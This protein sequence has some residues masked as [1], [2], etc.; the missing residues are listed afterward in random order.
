MWKFD[1]EGARRSLLCFASKSVDG[2]LDSSDRRLQP[3]EYTDFFTAP[4]RE[5]NLRQRRRDGRPGAGAAAHKLPGAEQRRRVARRRVPAQR[6]G[7]RH[8]LLRG[9]VGAAGL[10]VERRLPAARHRQQARPADVGRAGLGAARDAV[11]HRC[12]RHRCRYPSARRRRGGADP[13]DPNQETRDGR[14]RELH[15]HRRDRPLHRRATASPAPAAAASRSSTRRP[16]RSARQVALASPA[17]VDAAV[18]AAKARRIPAWADTPPLRRAR[19]LQRFLEP[20]QPAARHAR[21]DDHRRARQGLQRR[22]GRGH[23]RHRHR[24]VRVRH[25]DRC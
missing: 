1:G 7:L 19:V 18:A 20:A 22:A 14:Q 8:G 10:A 25:P 5:R 21:G 12:G 2:A 13:N 15:Q 9:D 6:P 16:A 24:R 23:A 4:G 11:A 17:E 3:A